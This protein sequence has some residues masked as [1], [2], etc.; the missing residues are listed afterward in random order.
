MPRR[1]RHQ[2]ILQFLRRLDRE[3]PLDLDLHL[4]VDNSGTHKASQGEELARSPSALPSPFHSDQLV[5]VESGRALVWSAHGEA[6]SARQLFSL[7][8]LVQA[9]HEYLEENNRQP[10]PFLWTASVEKLLE[11]ANRCKAILETAH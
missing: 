5:V 10:K 6:D 8:E 2:E 9:I 7:E 4:I 11:K 3:F 1:H